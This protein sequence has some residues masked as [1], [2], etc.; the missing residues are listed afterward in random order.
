MACKPKLGAECHK[1]AVRVEFKGSRGL[2]ARLARPGTPTR[3]KIDAPI[4]WLPGA[5][6]HTDVRYCPLQFVRRAVQG[7]A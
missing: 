7:E 2:E 6:S 4:R 3:E 1:T 5:L